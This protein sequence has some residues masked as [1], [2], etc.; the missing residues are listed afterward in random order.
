MA[1]GEIEHSV[2]STAYKLIPESVQTRWNAYRAAL[3]ESEE[4]ATGSNKIGD[5]VEMAGWG[6]KE[7]DERHKAGASKC[8]PT[9][10]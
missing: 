4:E 3:K 1:T 5:D 6:V 7:A 9:W 10:R 8:G 2:M